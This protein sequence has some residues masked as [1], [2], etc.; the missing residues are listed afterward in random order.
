MLFKRNPLKHTITLGVTPATMFD[1][2]ERNF[3]ILSVRYQA[4]DGE[5]DYIH[6][7]LQVGN[8][9]ESLKLS[10]QEAVYIGFINPEGL[11]K[12]TTILNK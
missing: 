6:I 9:V 5:G 4:V 8:K 11:K 10:P 12:H 3:Q 2:K 7:V 1:N